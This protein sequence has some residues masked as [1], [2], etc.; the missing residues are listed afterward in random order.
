MMIPINEHQNLLRDTK[1]MG[2][3]NIDTSERHK[4][5]MSKERILGERRRM[6]DLEKKV[7]GLQIIL[8]K[9]LEK[10]EN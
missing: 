3:I 4:Y 8:Q 10:L 2:V 5:L 7:D 9:I 1:S 6:E